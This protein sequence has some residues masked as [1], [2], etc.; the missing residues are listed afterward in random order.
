MADITSHERPVCEVCQ[1]TGSTIV[2]KYTRSPW[3]VV[4]C[5][6]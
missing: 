1:G 5:N 6:S 2:E 3:P 4:T